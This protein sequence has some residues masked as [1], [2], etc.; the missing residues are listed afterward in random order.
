MDEEQIVLLKDENGNNVRFEQIMTFEF[1]ESLYVAITPEDE[2]DGI[3]NGDVM[4]LEIRE[5]EDGHS[6]PSRPDQRLQ[7]AERGT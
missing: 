4:L 3:K 1:E 7:L 2:V 6:P 5:D